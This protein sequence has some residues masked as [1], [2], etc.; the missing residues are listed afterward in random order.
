MSAQRSKA[1]GHGG[2]QTLQRIQNPKSKIQN[3]FLVA[4]S[5]LALAATAPPDSSTSPTPAPA[6]PREFFNAGTKNLSA[7]KL[8]EAEAFLESTLASQNQKLQPAA[9]YNLG[10]VRFG[11]GIEELKKGP[12]A[13]QTSARGKAAV[14]QADTAIHAADQALAQTDVQTLVAAYMRGR[15]TRKELKAAMAAV[16]RALDTQRN[17]L[18][19]WQRASGDFRSTTELN[20]AD[21][22][23]RQNAE[24]VDRSIA[25]L[26]DMIQQ[27]QQLANALGEKK[28]ELGDKMKQ[29]KG[30]MP[31]GQLPGGSGDDE[32]DEDSPSGIPPGQKEG[33]GKE[34]EQMAL[35]PE[36]AGWLLEGFKLDAE[37]RLPMGQGPEAQPRE[38]NRPDW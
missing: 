18:H 7:G 23:A 1:A 37:H 21:A 33:P 20:S 26:V 4:L 5:L 22:D 29:M 3:Q 9:L 14:E 6:S 24:V 38:R 30:K 2:A 16:A 34:G 11:Q 10:H 36:Q 35:T 31:D 13:G 12:P 25:R 19:K 28:S 8:R 32:E 27:M 17:A 15:G